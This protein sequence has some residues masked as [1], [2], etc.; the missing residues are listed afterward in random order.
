M[1]TAEPTKEKARSDSLGGLNLPANFGDIDRHF[2]AFIE[3]LSGEP[4]RELAL[5]AALVSRSRGEGDICLDLQTVAGTVLEPMGNGPQL[6]LP[7][8]EEWSAKLRASGVVGQPGDFTPLVLDAAGRLYLHRYW[9]YESKLAGAILQRAEQSIEYP[10]EDTLQ[11]GLAKFFPPDNQI[12]EPDRQ[13]LAAL[14]ALR[15]WI[16]IISGGPGTGKTRTVT[17]ILALLLEQANGRPLRIALAAPTGKAAARLQESIKSLKASLPCNEDIK[18]RLPEE[19]FTVHRLLGF[20]PGSPRFRFHGANPLPFDVVVVDEASMVD[21]A[22]MAKLFAAVPPAARVVLLGDKDQLAS[23]EAGAV[24]NDIC[25]GKESQPPRPLSE[26]IVEL[27]KNYRFGADSDILPLSRAVNDG[28]AG[29]TIKLLTLPGAK[30]IGCKVLPS[31]GRLKELLREPVLAGFGDTLRATEP[32]AA[33][34]RLG[35][36]RILCALRQGPFGVEVVNQ[37]VEEILA[38]ARLVPAR[39]RW[40]PVKPVMVTRNDHGLKLFNGDTGVV[41]PDPASGEPRVWFPGEDRKSVV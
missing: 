33:L 22:L 17:G 21:L 14:T 7:E 39:E 32:Q 27:S 24:L 41:W 8:L 34:N 28:D 31:A 29:E 4:N 40:Y 15:K 1:K 11:A 25:C 38:E 30:G 2:T 6:A 3:R 26:C 23:V 9:E 10:D 35:R 37:L 5:A 16:C 18:A 20:V 12:G 36:F 19:S 13:R